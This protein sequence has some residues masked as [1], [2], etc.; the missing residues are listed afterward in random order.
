M[1]VLILSASPQRDRVVDELISTK[2]KALGHETW[3]R[4]CLREGRA[5]VMELQP[6]VVVVPPIRNPYAR[7]FAEVCKDWGMGVVSRHTEASA[8]W[9]DWKRMPQDRRHEIVG[10]FPY[11]VDVELVWGDDEAQILSRRSLSVP[12]LAVGSFACDV[13]KSDALNQYIKPYEV[14]CD[15]RKLD[16]KKKTL[17]ISSPWGF[18]DSAPDLKIPEMESIK[19]DE[20]DRDR[21]IDMIQAVVSGLP[22]DWQVLVT[23]HPGITIE[24]YKAK[25]PNLT[26]DTESSATELLANT[27]ALVHA[28]STMSMEMHWLNKPAYQFGDVNKADSGSWW[29]DPQSWLSKVSPYCK[30]PQEIL[31]QLKSYAPQSNA[32]QEALVVLEAG[33]YGKMDGKATDRAVEVIDKVKGRFKRTWPKAT[34]DYDQLFKF[35]SPDRIIQTAMCGICQRPMYGVNFVWVEQMC[36]RLAGMGCTDTEALKTKLRQAFAADTFCPNCAAKFY[37]K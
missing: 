9:Q 12:V 21:H 29:A 31:D 11:I 25:L 36:C 13:Y 15:S 32:S 10:R 27:H 3:I 4:P 20:P 18:A 7:D 24:P 5:A 33:R 1:K 23:L 14:F 35:K 17:L 22:A 6:D 16:A 19:G 30:S 37:M 34:S 26:I 28:G 8:D 2:L